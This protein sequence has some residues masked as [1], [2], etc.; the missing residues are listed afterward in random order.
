MGRVR[1]KHFLQR[2]K[3]EALF[4]CDLYNERR[5][6]PN[7]EAFIVHMQIGWLNL[8]MAIFERDGVNYYYR[9]KRR[10]E[11]ID[12]EKKA[13][14]IT[15]CAKRYYT[16]DM[17]PA[18]QNLLFFVGLRNKIEHRFSPKARRA[19]G[20]LVSGR[21]QAFIANFER[22]LV[23]EFGQTESLAQELRFPLF[24]SSLTM[25]AV[26]AIKAVRKSVPKGI[27][28]YIAAYDGS[29]SAETRD[30]QAYE[31]RVLLIPMKSPKTT[32]DTSITFV[33]ERNLTDEQRAALDKAIVIVRERFT[34]VVGA[35]RHLVSQVVKKIRG[36]FPTFNTANHTDAWRYFK[37]RPK[38]GVAYPER[39]DA[40]YCVYD[41]AFK[42]YVYTDAW[43]A[44][45]I[46]EL[47][48]G[49]PKVT[50]ARWHTGH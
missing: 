40:E 35:G 23:T 28:D 22:V 47:R 20:L 42:S 24:L 29:L 15:Q 3:D 46:N 25:D 37:V 11:R 16:N 49:D 2:A 34:E 48:V 32:A 6:E 33:D 44:R 26:E 4:A 41:V 45:L 36:H 17:N 38:Y 10:Y 39:T 8:M 18:R 43:V 9:R 7:L 14:D 1:A 31:F 30:D 50:L 5:R 13:W 27:I 19:L 12:G 21:A